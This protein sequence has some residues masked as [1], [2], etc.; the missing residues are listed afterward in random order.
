MESF[1]LMG[2]LYVIAGMSLVGVFAPHLNDTLTQR[3][4]LSFLSIGA[5]GMIEWFKNN[6]IP[7]SMGML[8]VGV[9]LFMVATAA[10]LYKSYYENKSR[11]RRVSDRLLGG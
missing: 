11:R 8:L 5:L 2:L 6:D 7:W 10:K 1:F 3:V 9:G 4:G